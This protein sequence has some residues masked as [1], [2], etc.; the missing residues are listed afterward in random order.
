MTERRFD[1]RT[2]VITG[3]GRGLGREYALLLASKGAK[4]VVNDPGGA[5]SG[6]GG[7]A[8]PAEQVVAEIKAAGGEAVACLESVATPEGG[9]AIVQA[10]MDHYGR[11]DVLIHN[12]GNVRYGALDEITD[13]DFKAVVDVHLM[14]A[15]HVVRPAF[16]LMTKAG[17][18][19]VVLTG[20]IG[21]LY[22]T[23]NVVNYGV[24]K[25][26][27]IGLNNV[28]AI[29]GAPKGVKSN[30]ILPGAV[31]RMADGLDISQYPPMGPDLVAPVVGWLAHE[32]CSISGEMLVSMA[33]RVAR[34]LIAE[35]PGVFR[36]SWSIDDVA[37]EIDAIRDTKDLWTLPQAEAYFEHMGRSF[38]MA[39]KG[40]A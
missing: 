16:P 32:S 2:A 20:S 15:F 6:A 29:E 4:V 13:E 23:N 11:L 24:S 9:R 8:G 3:A 26:G 35:T 14:G 36:P 10:A 22:G 40:G 5:M 27:M 17:Y 30:I 7:D 12:A 39:R 33:G 19:R 38:E 34:A 37:D 21:G 1:G 18:G 25:A 31:T 28:I